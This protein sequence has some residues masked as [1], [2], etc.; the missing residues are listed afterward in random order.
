[1]AANSSLSLVD[2]D[3]DRLR[4]SLVAFMRNQNEF[5]SYDFS[6]S[7]LRVLIDLLSYN[8]H[9]NAFYTNMMLSE[10]F[11]DSAQMKS[12][13]ISH[14]KALNYTPRSY[15]SAEANVSITF[16]GSAPSYLLQKG[17]SFTST[18]KSNT[19]IFTVPDN[20]LLTSANGFFSA[21]V[22]LFEGS[23]VYDNY[24][25]NHSDVTQRFLI[26]NRNCDISSLSVV[27]YEN[28]NIIGTSFAYAST[29][30][31]LNEASK[32]FFVQQAENEQYEVIF[33]DGVIGY[34]PASGSTIALNYRISSGS[35][36]N[37]AKIFTINF[38]PG[39]TQDAAQ[40]NVQTIS[41]SAGGANSEDVESIRYF[42]PRHFQ[43]QERATGSSDYE[44]MLR[45]QFPEI[46]A[47][48]VFGGEELSPPRYGYVAICVDITDVDKIPDSKIQAYKQFLQDKNS[49][50]TH[51]IFI[52]PLYTYLSVRSNVSYNINKSTLTPDNMKTLVVDGIQNYAATNLGDFEDRFR[53]SK[54]CADIDAIDPSIVS[55]ETEI[56]IYKKISPQTGTVQNIDI[57][58]AAALKPGT[59]ISNNKT[60]VSQHSFYSSD[61][62]SNGYLSRLEDDG[63]GNVYIVTTSNGQETFVNKIGTIDYSSGKIKL[64]NFNPT[65]YDGN[66]IKFYARLLEKDFLADKATILGIESSEILVTIEVVRE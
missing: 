61:F 65:N 3:F 17:Q 60:S 62:Y 8:S 56:L 38:N 46:R 59:I 47:V 54:F 64:I 52:E 30:L 66:H 31:G 37:G 4:D 13:V 53:Y 41:V 24:V 28:N 33:G 29:L 48:S 12:S 58:F 36:G 9:I 39:P 21:N 45:T 6:S 26:S 1:M 22:S 16:T 18:I 57:D 44:I 7:N 43:I 14:A 51:T 25:M 49:L 19:Y 23:Y 5:K 35:D 11:L 55:N 10:A 32:V 15:R 42:A 34:K 40:I 50:T 27:V 2:L 63:K 20:I